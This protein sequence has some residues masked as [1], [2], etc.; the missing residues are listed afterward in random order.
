MRC[1][2]FAVADRAT[3]YHNTAAATMRYHAC[4]RV[5]DCASGVDET[6]CSQCRVNV[7]LMF[8]ESWRCDGVNDC[9]D[10]D[11]TDEADCSGTQCR[12]SQG[13]AL[14]TLQAA[15]EPKLLRSRSTVAQKFLECCSDITQLI[16]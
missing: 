5:K 11:D 4:N 2:F 9:M 7:N 6:G 3:R 15:S 16:S 13:V 12:G 8:H 1:V 14:R 10:G